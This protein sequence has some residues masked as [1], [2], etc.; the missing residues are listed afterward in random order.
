MG[1]KDDWGEKTSGEGARGAG[2]LLPV[3]PILMAEEP[4]FAAMVP[5]LM[6]VGAKVPQNRSL[7]GGGGGGGGD[8]DEPAVHTGSVMLDVLLH[9]CPL[10]QVAFQPPTLL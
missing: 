6:P 3:A 10:L 7:V 2:R 1:R 5:M 4:G 8:P 9:D